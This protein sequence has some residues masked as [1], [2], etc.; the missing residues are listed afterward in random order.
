MECPLCEG[1]GRIA[2][3]H[4][5]VLDVR[6]GASLEEI[7]T[8]FRQRAKAYHP[9]VNSDPRAN[10]RMKE[11]TAART[12]LTRSQSLREGVQC[13]VCNGRKR[14]VLSPAEE[15]T[16]RRRVDEARREER[17]HRAEEE[18]LVKG[19]VVWRNSRP[20]RRG[21]EQ[22]MLITK[23]RRF[24]AL[25]KDSLRRSESQRKHRM[26]IPVAGIPIARMARMAV[27]ARPAGTGAAGSFS[28]CS[29]WASAEVGTTTG[30]PSRRWRANPLRPR[31][32]RRAPYRVRR[33][34]RPRFPLSPLPRQRQCPVPTRLPHRCR[35]LHPFP[36]QRQRLTGHRSRSPTHGASG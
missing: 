3:Q 30:P 9:D 20:L 5:T 13:F 25:K 18:R 16:V 15:K 32:R 24:I 6:L 7:D 21:T 33:Q 34:R 8:A 31:L 22:R 36:Q 14:A 2:T 29:S 19:N 4:H 27:T 23:R 28:C 17:R 26:E 12:L 11:I 10:E 1:A 35:L